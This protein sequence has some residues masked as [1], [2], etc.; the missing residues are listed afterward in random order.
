M[1]AVRE[2]T[3]QMSRLPT[4]RVSAAPSSKNPN[5][6]L[7]THSIPSPRALSSAQH[8]LSRRAQVEGRPVETGRKRQPTAGNILRCTP[9]GQSPEETL[10][11]LA[12]GG[13]REHA[14]LTALQPSVQME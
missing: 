4:A 11:D 7:L 12:A 10:E 8:S 2:C 3:R 5:V 6:Q 14:A 13:A 1:E 9:H